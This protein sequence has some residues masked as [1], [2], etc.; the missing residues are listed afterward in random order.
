MGKSV[1]HTIRR[2]ESFEKRVYPILEG[3]HQSDRRFTEAYNRLVENSPCS[4]SVRKLYEIARGLDKK[5]RTHTRSLSNL[6]KVA[7]HNKG[8][9]ELHESTLKD[10]RAELASLKETVATDLREALTGF[11][12]DLNKLA[13]AEDITSLADRL[14]KVEEGETQMQELRTMFKTYQV[15]QAGKL[16]ETADESSKLRESVEAFKARL[17]NLEEKLKKPDFKAEA[18]PPDEPTDEELP[19][20]SSRLDPALG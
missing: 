13:K 16:T 2:L 1:A 19:P 11:T 7:G 4:A 15:T 10:T 5:A 20:S 14:S 18:T 17:D 8:R 6:L 9:V 12:E 3:L